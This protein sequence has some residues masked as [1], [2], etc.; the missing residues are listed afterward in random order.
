M[1]SHKSITKMSGWDDNASLGV[2]SNSIGAWP[3]FLVWS[4]AVI[5]VKEMD[6]ITI[7]NFSHFIEKLRNSDLFLFLEDGTNL[8]IPSK[9]FLPLQVT[10]TFQNSTTVCVLNARVLHFFCWMQLTKAVGRFKNPGGQQYCGIY[11][12]ILVVF[13]VPAQPRVKGMSENS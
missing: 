11:D 9:I 5:L 2:R 1:D 13:E 6:Q 7:P 3:N 4:P 8:K 12:I 10:S